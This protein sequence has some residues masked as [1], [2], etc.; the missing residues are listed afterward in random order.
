MDKLKNDSTNF[1]WRPERSSHQGNTCINR[2][3]NVSF[4]G[5]IQINHFFNVLPVKRHYSEISYFF[6]QSV[7][8]RSYF[9]KKFCWRPPIFFFISTCGHFILI[10]FRP[11]EFSFYAISNLSPRSSPYRETEVYSGLPERPE[12]VRLMQFRLTDFSILCLFDLGTFLSYVILTFGNFTKNH[13]DLWTFRNLFQTRLHK[14][15]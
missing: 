2:K 12:I 3:K 13:F 6:L 5:L 14:T 7:M 15:P 4:V 1:L 9:R 11:S 8:F 10:S